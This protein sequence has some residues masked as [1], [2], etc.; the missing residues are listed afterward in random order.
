MQKEDETL[1]NCIKCWRDVK[2]DV[3]SMLEET[4]IYVFRKGLRD[5][6]FSQKFIQ[7]AAMILSALF[8]VANKYVMR[9]SDAENAL[10]LEGQG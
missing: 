4:T 10:V 7:M 5:K 1:C 9:K 8:Q 6:E 2:V 3:S